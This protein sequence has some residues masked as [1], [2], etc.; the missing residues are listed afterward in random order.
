MN[1]SEQDPAQSAAVGA[2]DALP[3]PPAITRE[4]L[5]APIE[6][7]GTTESGS[8][9]APGTHTPPGNI[10]H[11]L[12]FAEETH[13]YIREYIRLADQKATFFFTGGTALLAF[14][15]KANVSSHWLKPIMTWNVLDV[16][17]FVAMAALAV[18]AL[19]SMLVV[20]PRTPGSL[21][22]YL[23][24]EAIAEYESARTY[25]DE[26]SQLSSASL[27]QIKAEHSYDLARVCRRKY[28]LL[29]LALRVGA[30]GLGA[31]L[32]VFLF[33]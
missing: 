1:S 26:V 32:L 4:A 20:I 33:V 5:P 6:V 21:R 19:A 8:V 7:P 27:F 3:V 30:V 25:A 15:Y 9:A 2:R 17:A 31:A 18:A 23:F 14:L 16:V 28:R 11:R 29:R 24:W 13:Q 12:R 22:G 10:D